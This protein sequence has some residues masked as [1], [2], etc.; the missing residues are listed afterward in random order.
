MDMKNIEWYHSLNHPILS[1]PDWLFAPIWSILYIL[2]FVSL[3]IIL[4][5]GNIK[6]KAAPLSIFGVQ[7]VFNLLWTPTFFINKNISGALIVSIFL[8]ITVY[9]TI[10]SFYPYSKTAAILL[11]P[12]LL[13]AMFAL[14]LNFSIWKLN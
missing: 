1:P 11:I 10:R 14:Y 13:W 3:I 5:D 9:Q 4:K 6:E 8:V 2:M 12:Y 7:L